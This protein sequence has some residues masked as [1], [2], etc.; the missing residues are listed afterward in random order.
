MS[1]QIVARLGLT[2]KLCWLLLG[3]VALTGLGWYGLR[4]VYAESWD[5]KAP[6]PSTPN[7][8]LFGDVINGKIYVLG[9]EAPRLDVY[10]PATNTWDTTR[11]AP[12]VGARYA[13]AVALN[14]K[15]YRIGGTTLGG[16]NSSLRR[17]DVYDPATNTWDTT[18]TAMPTARYQM[19]AAA[20]AGKIYVVGGTD[21]SSTL[22]TLEVYDPAT[23]QWTARAG[24]PTARYSHIAVGI[25]GK[26]YVT[27]GANNL[28][29]INTLE[30]YDPATN[31]WDTTK[32]SMP[33]ARNAMAAAVLDGKLYTLGG[34]ITL[35]GEKKMEVYDPGANQWTTK[36][37]LPTAHQNFMAGSVNGKIYAVAGLNNTAVE[38][39]DPFGIPAEIAVSEPGVGNIADGGS[40]NFGTTPVGT[41]IT[42]TFTLANSGGAT[43]ILSNLSVTTGFTIT[44]NF[45]STSVAPN[46]S[47]TFQITMAATAVGTPSGTLSFTNNDTDENPY[48]FTIG[49]TVVPPG[50]LQFSSSLYVANE[51]VGVFSVTV[52]RVNGTGGT[53]SANYATS[54]GTA[55]AGSDYISANGTVT[56]LDG[57]TSRS[58]M[59]SIIWDTVNEGNETVNLTL[60][61]PAGGA[62]LGT[63]STATLRINNVPRTCPPG[64]TVNDLGDADDAALGDNVCATAGGVCT[65]RAAIREAN[66]SPAC[67]PLTINFS[68]TGTITLQN[69]DLF[70]SHSNL[71]IQGPGANLLT[72]SANEDSR[73]FSLNSSAT[74]SINNLTITNGRSIDQGGGIYNQ[75]N[76]T[77]SGCALTG[78]TAVATDNHQG[79]GGGIY[80]LFGTLT[81][82]NSTISG[83]AVLTDGGNSFNFSRG[84]GIYNRATLKLANSTISGNSVSGS[85]SGDNS[86]EGGGIYN[87]SSGVATISNSTISNNTASASGGSNDMG[88]GGGIY[89]NSGNAMVRNVIMAGNSVSAATTQGPDAFGAINTLGNNLL[90]KDDGSSGFV[91]GSNGD[92]VGTIAD[93]LNAQLGQLAN[94]GGPTLT[95]AL[96]TGSPAINAGNNCVLTNTCLPITLGFN[97]T[98]DQRG[99]GFNR[100]IG[101]TVDI[102]AV[103]YPLI[104]SAGGPYTISE[105]DSLTL[106]GSANSSGITYSWDVNGDGTF[107]DA[108]G[109][110]PTLTWTQLMAL[111]IN[112]GP[113]VFNNVKVRAND[114]VSPAADSAAASLTVNN[115][116]P[117]I[118]SVSGLFVAFEGSPFNTTVQFSD[119]A[120]ANDTYTLTINWGDG[121]TS[122]IPNVVSGQT[123]SHTYADGD[124]SYTQSI[125]VTDSDNAAST[126]F[127]RI[128]NVVNIAPNIT[129]V[130]VPATVAEGSQVTVTANFTDP[131]GANDIY[132]MTINWGDG[133]TEVFNNVSFTQTYTHTYADGPATRTLDFQVND[134]GPTNQFSSHILKTLTV[135]NVAPTLTLSGAA[136]AGIGMPYTLNLASN[137]PGQDTI[138][139]WTIHWGDGSPAQVV[140]GNPSSVTHSYTSAPNSFTISATATDEDGT[141]AAGNTVAVTVNCTNNPVVTNG[142]DSGA[143]SLRE[144]IALACAGSTI[145]FAIGVNL[146]TLTSGELGITKNLTIQGPEGNTVA[147]SGNNASRVLNIFQAGTVT[148]NNLAV[149]NGRADNGGGIAIN[150]TTVNINN[151][152]VA[153]NTATGIGGGIFNANGTLNITASAIY[154]NTGSQGGGIANGGTPSVL[155]VTN[156]TISGNT[157]TGNGGGIFT[158][159]QVTVRNSTITNNLAMGDGISTG[160]GGG[161]SNFSAEPV[162]LGNT[163]IAGNSAPTA[164]DFRDTLT[165]LGNNLVGNTNGTNLIG[166]TTGNIL[167]ANAR[168]APLGNYGGPT[169]TH[170]LL[171]GSPAINAGDNCVLTANGCGNNNPAIITDQRGIARVGTVDIGAFESRGFT[172]AVSS[173][174]KQSTIAGTAFASPLRVTVASP[175]GE[176]VDGGQVTFTPPANGASASVIG[177]P[178]T[179]SAGAAIT[180]TITANALSGS[181]TITASASGAAA[182]VNFNLTN[183]PPNSAPTFTPAAAISRQQGSPAG[184]A[185]TIGMV[186]DLETSPG[187][188]AVTQVAGGTASGIIV[189]NI[190]NK[191]G[192]I[193]A[194]ISA[195]C[196]A[197][198]GTVRFQVSDGSLTGIGDLTVNVTANSLPTISYN[199]VTVAVGASI[200]NSPTAAPDNGS[201]SGYTVQSAKT[202]SGTISVDAAGLVSISNAAPVGT[203]TITIRA[204]D[205]CNASSDASFTLTVT[206]SAPSITAQTGI[207]RQQG[208]PASN[209]QIATVKDSE[210]GGKGVTVTV[211]GNNTATVNGVTVSNISNSGGTVTANIVATC[212]ASNA[213]FTLT[214][215]DGNGATA[216]A[217]LNIAV[218]GITVNPAK[219]LNGLTFV[220][221]TETLS[222]AGGTGSYTFSV[223]SGSL[224]AGLMI[225]G[226]LLVGTP[227]AAGA[228]TFTIRATDTSNGCFGERS[229]TV[230]IGSTG[231]MYYPLARPVRLLDTR[232][233]ASPN[234]CF[235]PNAPIT[236]G[237]VRTQSARGTCEG[238]VIPANATT[239]TGHITTVQSGGGSLTLY[240]SDA[241][242]PNVSNSNYLVNEIL[243]NAFTVGL[244]VSDGAFKI[245]VGTSTDVVI[246]VTGYYAP[247]GAGGLYFHPLPKPIRLLETRT[248]F[249][250]CQAIGTPLQTG[251]T[252]LQTGVL[253][254]EGVT[255]PMGA[256]ALVGNATTTNST[257]SGYLTLWPADANQPF[258][259]SS[260][261]AAGINRNAPFTVG[262]SLNGEFN[263]YTA[264]T[265]DLVIDVMGYYSTQAN[266]VNGQGL[267]FN[268]LGAPLRLMDTRAGQP[269]CYQP[270]APMTSQ[271]VYTQDTQI[272]CTNLTSVARGLVGNVSALNATANGFVTFW[273]SNATQPTVATSNYQTGRV[274]NRHFTVGLGPDV[275]FKRY[276]LTTTDLIIDISGFFA[277]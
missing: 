74:A 207:T 92:L 235:Q 141:Y 231:L 95:H 1:K 238:I 108:T 33:I 242:Q 180:G 196:T 63:P 105:G 142:N 254:C 201:I 210:S 131:G 275:A 220:P 91:Q 7:T 68:V 178:A 64:F 138:T 49:G 230:N 226:N 277:P 216:T 10:D 222:A 130:D 264:R 52:N 8:E 188:L 99:T 69:R 153:N 35:L 31:T 132:T 81:I 191:G 167:N 154:G 151:S 73:V 40:F 37:D 96:L 61:N 87:D 190:T 237:T 84:G 211:N 76:L 56:F 270:G 21:G 5:I 253:T 221:Y 267:L 228:S 127:S 189:S 133:N 89:N 44:S 103:E 158:N 260:N 170:A 179:I 71:T 272:P 251:T 66:A 144:A 111:G 23:N 155:N 239:I 176:P 241:P 200:G 110:N 248:G 79:G 245:F 136:T 225:N 182:G 129:S 106:N 202:F 204:T 120:G 173:G 259:S 146:I 116:A 163:I 233:G 187:S 134:E 193:T 93:P 148:L 51:D 243:N 160:I 157:S 19:A 169:Q 28:G 186:N 24:V 174:D 147:I 171:P 41:P 205:N 121:N 20:I 172:L 212:G 258:A 11:A 85:G 166:T 252:R 48:N 118:N 213:S 39:Y 70:V 247:P 36:L 250:G 45:G 195:S 266:D 152:S 246:D 80:N 100:R 257:G 114:G 276:T 82:I 232:P 90:G 119:P 115:T 139:S 30:I 50:S 262:L 165:S 67:S 143:G 122:V 229:Y 2:R 16:P 249:T 219:L 53:V 14:G 117:T 34:R 101:S 13:S 135:L 203:H 234:A 38:V 184:N 60:S 140:A 185:T 240:P 168:L 17:L 206:N 224:P 125:Y 112:D 192:T 209:S 22:N 109:Q 46:S 263:I 15:L 57:E 54:D 32:A 177:N 29:N 88:R 273:P 161:I 274:F 72:I 218:T 124:I 12:P 113:A 126:T 198:G 86:G 42:K 175:S 149:T 43:L 9:G 197:V 156:S 137:D 107:G 271:T 94:N 104:S 59:I 208:A 223:S 123:H 25:N 102:G 265:T 83:N 268:S 18:R 183:I 164:P 261:F 26:L 27:G 128:V 199:N 58:F 236:G 150:G 78:N 145:T 62:S 227:T 256:Q 269:A 181:Y 162:S 214:A 6:Y 65:L 194:Q 159:A 97:L 55:T 98:T 4:T 244:G 3:V 255:I 47:T 75:G 217:T 215:T 77:L